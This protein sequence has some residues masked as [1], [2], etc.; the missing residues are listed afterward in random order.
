MLLGVIADD[1]TGAS[2]IANTLTKGLPGQ[3]GLRTVQYLGVP[4][5]P[6]QAGVEA[7]VVSLK[8]RSAPATA[9]VEQS[10]AALRWLL[11]QGATQIVFKY[12]STFD[13]TPEG[14]IGPVSEALAQA[15]GVRGVVV[16]PAFPGAG[17]T[18]YQG[19]LF[20]GDALLNES[21]M[22]HHPLTPMTDPDIRRWLRRQTKQAI[23]HVPYPIVMAGSVA[24]SEALRKAAEGGE[25]L[26]VVDA[27]DDGDLTA[28]GR[29]LDDVPL[30][31]GGSGIA[32]ALPANFIARGLASGGD[33]GMTAVRGAEAILAGSCSR[34]T[35]GQIAHHRSSHPVQMISVDAAMEDRLDID[36]LV[37]FVMEN[38]GKA[39]LLYSSA[40]PAEI[41]AAQHRYG[42][43]AVAD[44]LDAL[45]GTIACRLAAA[46]LRR[47]VV[48]GGETSGAVV[49]AL[50]IESLTV[51]T[52]IDAGV[53]ILIAEKPFQMGL[54]L[55]SGNFGELDF[56]ERA[57]TRIAGEA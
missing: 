46:G 30:L 44:T 32:R 49:G 55:K 36:D 51:G 26:V 1:F 5:G 16:C 14:N 17:R 45:F 10:L 25:T 38:A 24:I 28:I 8:S 47:L 31:S 50:G 37:T 57:L 11:A 35:R 43:E 7:G 23:G 13:S 6:V 9:A 19:H 48:A 33:I 40:E 27:V 41:V 54:A 18:V 20:V 56:F 12:C 2:D 21:G 15:L 53:P 39:P 3:G 52:E 42:R 34:A 29:A 4:S 22:E